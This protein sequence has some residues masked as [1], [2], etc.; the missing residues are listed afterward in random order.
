MDEPIVT[1]GEFIPADKEVKIQKPGKEN[2]QYLRVS[3]RNNDQQDILSA[4][5][6]VTVS[7][8]KKQCWLSRKI[9]IANIKNV[10]LGGVGL[11]SRC[12]L[13]AKQTIYLSLEGEHFPIR[14][15]HIENI[16]HKLNFI[17]AKWALQD[18]EQILYIT[19]KIYNLSRS[20]QI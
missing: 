1:L 5:D 18:E 20:P 2:R 9:G 4:C 3:L 6:G 8:V 15:M 7:L 14:V 12:N 19:N 11:I 16:S 13:Q 10:G 17:G